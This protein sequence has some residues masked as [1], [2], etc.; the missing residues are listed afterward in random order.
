[1]N[2]KSLVTGL[3]SFLISQSASDVPRH[4]VTKQFYKN[5][6]LFLNVGLRPTFKNKF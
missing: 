1:M 6:N 3:M 2:L 5:P 4:T